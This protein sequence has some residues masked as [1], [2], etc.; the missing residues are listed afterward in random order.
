M[1]LIL[2]ACVAISMLVEE[3]D[4]PAARSLQADFQKKIHELIAPDSLPLEIAHALT[5]AERQ[6][7]IDVGQGQIAFDD[8]LDP[9]PTLYP[10]FDYLDRAI[11]LSSKFRIGVFDCVYVALSE[12]H[13]CPVVTSDKR[14]LEL[15]PSL[16]IS[17]S[18]L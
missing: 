17:L 1:K 4:T 9:C 12:E 7:K 3:N 6:G 13:G 10:Y 18:D 16:T 2:D 15:F 5:R 11:R 14:F 8:F